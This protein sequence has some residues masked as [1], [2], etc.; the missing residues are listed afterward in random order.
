MVRREGTRFG[1]AT[2]HNVRRLPFPYKQLYSRQ[3]IVVKTKIDGEDHHVKKSAKA[4]VKRQMEHGAFTITGD[5]EKHGVTFSLNKAKR[6]EVITDIKDEEDYYGNHSIV[7]E[8][9][10]LNR[11]SASSACVGV[12]D[13]LA[14]EVSRSPRKKYTRA[15]D[16]LSSKEKEEVMNEDANFGKKNGKRSKKG[17]RHLEEENVLPSTIQYDISTAPPRQTFQTYCNP[18]GHSDLGKRKKNS[19]NRTRKHQYCVRD[20]FSNEQWEM[21]EDLANEWEEEEEQYWQEETKD[22]KPYQVCADALAVLISKGMAAQTTCT[23]PP[24]NRRNEV[25]PGS[26]QPLGTKD[27]VFSIDRADAIT[28][29]HP[30]YILSVREERKM[31]RIALETERRKYTL[32][33]EKEQEEKVA[34]QSTEMHEKPSVAASVK[35]KDLLSESLR[36]KFGERYIEGHCMPR[37]FA[38][39]ITDGIVDHRKAKNEGDLI[40]SSLLQTGHHVFAVFDCMLDP[41]LGF[42]SVDKWA[43]EVRVKVCGVTEDRALLT[44]CVT[45]LEICGISDVIYTTTRAVAALPVHRYLMERSTMS[46]QVEPRIVTKTLQS[47]LGWQYEVTSPH[48]ATAQTIYQN[49][50][51]R[52]PTGTMAPS[53]ASNECDYCSICYEELS[54]MCP[55]TALT[56]C[57]HWFCDQCWSRHMMSRVEQGDLNITC[58]G[59]QC[60]SLVDEV[61][62]MSFL[63]S[64]FFAR[65]WNS[66]VNTALMLHPELRWCPS[67]SCGRLLK[68]SSHR[69][70]VGNGVGI[71]VNCS[72]GTFWCSECKEEAHWPASCQQAEAY[73]KEAKTLLK[74]QSTR[75]RPF[76][77]PTKRC[78]RCHYPIEKS[79]GCNHMVCKCGHEFCWEC[80]QNWENGH[81]YYRCKNEGRWKYQMYTIEPVEKVEKSA[82]ELAVMHHR[83]TTSVACHRRMRKATKLASRMKDHTN[84]GSKSDSGRNLSHSSPSAAMATSEINPLSY[85]HEIKG[86]FRSTA[87][88][89]SEAEFVLQHLEIFLSNAPPG[90]QKRVLSE[91]RARLIFILDV[92]HKIINKAAKRD[93]HKIQHLLHC[94]KSSLKWIALA[95]TRLSGTMASTAAKEE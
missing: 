74:L 15:A 31:R 17:K 58:P 57:S 75:D 65:H 43:E 55:G 49:T 33:V 37:R 45:G 36:G 13:S 27:R 68:L 76:R 69:T 56:A 78:P 70:D 12:Y 3:S 80:G 91:H 47:A 21:E 6:W 71:P 34:E 4:A 20:V 41:R 77:V 93:I 24:R 16:L 84:T 18:A 61:T 50:G 32:E 62:L 8:H 23:P 88:F 79:Y 54:E 38:V 90:N 39:N 89:I 66:K 10:L 30:A 63:P 92:L 44:K 22:A 14:E 95:A 83:N 81:F 7:T 35:T 1:L 82:L 53:A 52:R 28:A 72:C 94:G 26:Q 19:R 86:I 73:R 11:N 48:K 60:T 2:S 9:H 64:T 85:H 25:R 51:Q 5:D 59:Y 29:I 40:A 67:P 46:D 87:T 42:G